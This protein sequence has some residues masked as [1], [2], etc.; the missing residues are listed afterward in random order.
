MKTKALVI[1]GTA[2]LSVLLGSGI[3]GYGAQERHPENQDHARP[4]QDS[5]EQARPAQQQHGQPQ[6][7]RPQQGQNRPQQH[8]EQQRS[9]RARQQQGP[10]QSRAP[11]QRQ[12]QDR[13]QQHSQ[14]ARGN[15]QFRRTPE[16]QRFRQSV[17]QQHR[18][19][20]WQSDH[21]SWSQ[22]G[23]YNGYRIPDDRFRGYFGRGHGFRI[24]GLPFLEVGGYPRFQY[25]GYWFSMVDPYP[26]S[27]GDD[28]YDTDDVYVNYVDNGYYL[29]NRRYP[30]VGIAISVSM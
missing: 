30:G 18:A 8:A 19:G 16:Q 27:W 29:Y 5:R 20:N 22:R 23:G 4:Q 7:A 2:V 1:T 28:W 25:G 14:Q 9:D 6:Q 17:W 3:S 11:Q 15:G 13:A 12:A 26:G 24:G 21:R 10:Q